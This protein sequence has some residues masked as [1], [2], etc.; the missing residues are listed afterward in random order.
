MNFAARGTALMLAAPEQGLEMA[1]LY[2]R[3]DIA[4]IFD[5]ETIRRGKAYHLDGRVRQMTVSDDGLAI[6]GAVAGQ[7]PKPYSQTISIRREKGTVRI[8]GYCSCPMGRNC[9][10]VAA[11]LLGHLAREAGKTGAIGLLAAAASA[12]PTAPA[13]A[14]GLTVSPGVSRWLDRLAAAC[15]TQ[16]AGSGRRVKDPRGLLYVLNHHAER[17]AGLKRHASVRPVVARTRK[18]GSIVEEKPYDPE[19]A[20]R[21]E[22]QVARFLTAEDI[23]IL[24]DLIWLKRANPA[25]SPDIV[26]APDA[27][28]ARVLGR[29]LATGRVR[30]LR[31]DGAAL[32]QGPAA[33]AEFAW[34]KMLDGAQWL[35]LAPRADP[36]GEAPS[37]FDDVMPLAPPHYIDRQRGLVGPIETGLPPALAAEAALSPSGAASEAALVRVTMT[38]RLAAGSDRAGG[39]AHG[40][41][42]PDAALALPLPDTPE[43]VE[44]RVFAPVPRLDLFV[45]GARMKPAFSW[46][47]SD[48]R[49][50]G[51][52]NAPLARLSFDYGDAVVSHGHSAACLQRVEGGKLIVIPRDAA[53]EEAALKRLKRLEFDALAHAPFQVEAEHEG[54]FFLYPS[55]RRNSYELVATFDDPDRFLAFSAEK[56]PV[57]EADGWRIAFSDDY[58]YRLAEGEATW[59]AETGEG[60]GIDW[61]SFELGIEFEG[62]RI[63]LIPALAKVIGA[64]PPDVAAA[65][66]GAGDSEWLALCARLRLYHTLGDGRLLPLPGER[67]A[68]ILKALI[69]LVGP[70][71]ERLD[72]E[73]VAIHRA[74]AAALAAFAGEAGGAIA[75]VAGRARNSTLPLCAKPARCLPCQTRRRRRWRL[76]SA[77][78]HALSA[79]S[80]GS[81]RSGGVR[82]EGAEHQHPRLDAHDAAL[83]PAV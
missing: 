81:K 62:H 76:A 33:R 74:E 18:D 77:C 49:H 27:L 24:R 11:V 51:N 70:R 73:R 4:R 61:F 15:E 6:S 8:T 43:G 63:N 67:V 47:A 25:T 12:A 9:K 78:R 20:T 58:P 48:P 54:A 44:T 36:G 7:R 83:Q 17:N 34:V 45:A 82:G 52:F 16:G 53:A 66:G 19:Y 40:K 2:S 68:P 59:W 28:A 50:K 65:A 26:L 57:L 55:S 38:R 39:G 41:H 21:G 60:S 22:E 64:L 14:A 56:A 3:D 1:A 10:H 29:V 31:A 5:A 71:R 32:A 35:T 46:Y 75:W 13:E 42:G 72:G 23:D 30:L 69:E 80:E 37:M 79:H